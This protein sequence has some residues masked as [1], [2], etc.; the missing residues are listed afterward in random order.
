LTSL[1]QTLQH[2]QALEQ[3]SK[4][5]AALKIYR[6]LLVL[7][8]S[9]PLVHARLG[10]LLLRLGR[11]AQAVS[12]LEQALQAEPDD[13]GHWVR[14]LSAFQQSDNMTR[15]RDLLDEAID[16]GLGVE[17]LQ[18][19][20]RALQEPPQ[21]RQEGLIQLYN[22][23]S[24]VSAEIAARLLIDDYPSHPLGWQILGAVL[25]DVGKL[26][27]SLQV[28]QETVKLFP[29][30][31]NALNNL[32]FTLLAMQDYGQAA[33]NARRALMLNPGLAAAQA[34]EAKAMAAMNTSGVMRF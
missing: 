25:H 23:G 9:H 5:E 1:T 29:Q 2:A 14:L 19:L 8:P 32:A 4:H 33:N 20:A 12:S 21:V 7:L 16:I 10:A 6:G 11:P 26:Q 28:K 27:E 18:T 31:A 15:A 3:R 34:I 22:Q 17:R 24:H 13:M 30:D